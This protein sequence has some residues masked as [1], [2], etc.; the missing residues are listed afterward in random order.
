MSR[1][2]IQPL[3]FIL[4]LLPF[5]G[6]AQPRV[7]CFDHISI[8]QGLSDLTV[9]CFA[10]DSTGFLWFGTADG[11]NKYDGHAF[12]VFR[13]DPRDSTSMAAGSVNGLCVDPSGTLWIA[14]GAG[15]SVLPPDS[16]IP[17]RVSNQLIYGTTIPRSIL[18][19]E[20]LRNGDV[21]VGTY[22]GVYRYDWRKRRFSEILIDTIPLKNVS[23]ILEARDGT[24]WI[25]VVR[26]GL[27]AFNRTTK[28]QRQF[29]P[30]HNDTTYRLDNSINRIKQDRSGRI[31]VAANDGLYWL[32]ST[33]QSFVA[34]TREQ[35]IGKD[36]ILDVLED[37]SGTIWAG[38][39][40]LGVARYRPET[41]DFVRYTNDPE[42]PQSLNSD[43][44]TRMFEDQGSVLWFATYRAGLNRY[45]SK[46][47]SFTRFVPRKTPGKGLS[48]EGVYSILEDRFGDIWMG[49]YDGGLN[50]YNPTK[51][52]YT[53]YRHA[54]NDRF[55]PSSSSILSLVGIQNG[56]LWVGGVGGLDRFERSTGRFIHYQMADEQHRSGSDREVKSILVGSDG[57]VWFGTFTG[58]L[59]Q[60]NPKSGTMRQFKYL[61]GDSLDPGSPGVWALCEDAKG[62]LWIGTYGAG[63]FVMDKHNETFRRFTYNEARPLESLRSNGIYTILKDNTGIL[64]I[65]TMGGGLTRIDPETETLKTYTVE[66][67]LPNN[68]IKGIRRDSHGS[69]W[70]SSDFGLSR[71]DPASETVTN[72][73]A[74]DGL[75]GN[76]FLSGA[77]YVG[78]SGRMY[79]GGEKGAVAFY[80]DSIKE[81]S[82]VPPV[83]ITSIRVVD[84][85][86]SLSTMHEFPH[87]SNSIA[88]EFVALDFAQPEKNRYAYMMEG[89]EQHWLQAGTRRY[90]GYTHLGPGSYTFR[91][92]G[93]NNDGVWN[94]RGASIT[95]T[96]MPPFWETWWFRTG[97]LAALVA[98]GAWFY[99]YR[100]NRLLDVER[101]RVKI[102][103]D[104]HD[105][106]GSS[107]TR[108]SLQSEL[109]QEGFEPEEM[110]RYLKNI[111]STSRELVST[112]SDI[113]W[114]IDSRN[115]RVENLIFK[116]R[117]SAINT[118]SPK[119]IEVQFAYSGLDLKQRLPVDK[120]ENIYLV[121]K[122]AVNNIVKHSGAGNAHIVIRN[123]HDK[124]TVVI[125]DDGKG[126][127]AG[128]RLNG[129]G[130]KNMRMRAQRLG[131][132]VDFLSDNGTRVVF[133]TKPL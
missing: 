21:A 105:D 106:I 26:H 20:S 3:T 80:P 12:T 47:S 122:E 110:N 120:R 119:G 92:R 69:L 48:G 66:D 8:E 60:L 36:L 27:L 24:L 99:N 37:R 11:L 67:G 57:Y 129:H 40:H 7:M 98:I 84:R 16:S 59:H 74:E 121:C 81:N 34:V 112:M 39:F 35:G 13:S 97:T 94:D 23:A 71:F 125:H 46:R 49:I 32:D 126:L 42:D 83:V 82:F 33:G 15:L 19:L 130:V 44:I 41:N 91:V 30:Y 79:F 65:G 96:I 73:K 58:G 4:C 108:I 104:L 88:F 52:S 89:L 116:I 14:T 132:T 64:W 113:V 22:E 50:R 75:M 38:T 55:S 133:T 62:R 93:S 18:C 114:S 90:A 86:Y 63:L 95:F 70:L 85:L 29:M 10:Q 25:A 77:H 43:R 118:L 123:D 45:S 131:G 6:R 102:A 109:I 124:F 128:V 61:G 101:L 87:D 28:A 31:W 2:S 53:Y 111:A 9:S 68:F 76:V 1:L 51:D 115:D 107:L 103:S 117:D 78:P 56:D 100:V 127:G 5:V 17:R 54:D 72:F